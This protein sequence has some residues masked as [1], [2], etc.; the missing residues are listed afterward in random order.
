M[1]RKKILYFIT[2]ANWGGAQRYVFDLATS[3]AHEG[4]EVTVVTGAPGALT[5][6]LSKEGIRTKTLQ[7]LRR[8]I[9]FVDEV[10]SFVDVLKI[11]KKE[12]PDIL[13][14]NSSKAAGLGALAGRFA[15]VPRI[16]VTAHGWAFNEDRP[17]WQIG[18]IYFLSWITV[19]LSHH[20]VV[21][22]EKDLADAEE[23]P[24]AKEK[25]SLVY[26]GINPPAFL[27][28]KSARKTLLEGQS[29]K[30]DRQTYW[31]GMIGELTKNKGYRYAIEAFAELSFYTPNTLFVIIGGGEDHEA[32]E[33]D[34]TRTGL[35]DRVILTGFRENAA[36]LLPAFDCFLMSSIKEGFPYVIVE[37]GHAKLPVVATKVGGIP[38]IV[39]EMNSGLLVSSRDP[40]ALS[41]ALR[42]II[43]NKKLATSLGEK[44]H[45]WVINEFSF[46]KMIAATRTAYQI[47]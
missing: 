35:R 2:K 45:T 29:V 14:L 42:S 5:D 22:S 36:T 15:R 12:K 30:T 4:H 10:R 46:E 27:D 7:T 19:L 16:V 23:F 31:I 43:E 3:F 8:D 34:I 11:L 32:I 9:S 41:I 24:F 28:K 1:E 40:H 17:L 26:L 37:A 47:L 38:E 6:R 44:L 33:R 13:H 18:F 20:T 21:V 39:T 25:A